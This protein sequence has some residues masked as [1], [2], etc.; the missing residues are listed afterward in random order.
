MS[1]RGVYERTPKM[2]AAYVARGRRCAKRG[3]ESPS[4]RHGDTNSPSHVVWKNILQRCRNPRNPSYAH[5]GAVGIGVCD[6]WCEPDAQ[7]YLNFVADAGQRPSRAHQLHRIDNSRGYEPGNVEW[8]SR[9][10][11]RFIHAAEALGLSA[12]EARHY[13]AEI[14]TNKET[15]KK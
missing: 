15:P 11:H 12:A 5:Y 6:R 14:N 9:A 1:P 13:L 10:A 8:L 2:R 7:G 3:A 4:F